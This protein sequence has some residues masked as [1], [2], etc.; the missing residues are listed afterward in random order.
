MATPVANAAVVRILLVESDPALSRSLSALLVARPRVGVDVVSNPEEAWERL[1]DAAPY[2]ISVI[3]DEDAVASLGLL[4]RIKGHSPRTKTIFLTQPGEQRALQAVRAGASHCLPKPVDPKELADVLA[5]SLR[6]RLHPIER[7]LAQSAEMATRLSAECDQERLYQALADGVHSLGFDRVRLYAMSADGRAL[8]AK[9]QAGTGEGAVA[10]LSSPSQTYPISREQHA[11]LLE[12]VAHV[13][14]AGAADRLTPEKELGLGS[15]EPLVLLPLR[16]QGKV[17]GLLSADN[18]LS[19]RRVR[20]R[21]LIPLVFLVT[22]A[23]AAL[24]GARLF[25]SAQRRSEQLE[26]LRRTTLAITSEWDRA[27]LLDAVLRQAVALL[28]A[29]GGGIYEY[30]PERGALE[31]ICDHN[32]PHNVGRVLRVGD[33]MAG[34][35]VDSGEPYLIVHDYDQWPGRSPIY[36]EPRLFGAVLEVPLRWGNR[37]LGVLYV[38]DSVGR[39]FTVEDAQLLGLFADQAAI[40][41]ANADLI[42]RDKGKLR[43]LEAL[44][45][46][47]REI[48]GDLKGIL[49]QDRLSLIARRAAEILDA[50]CC[51]VHLV[52]HEGE[53]TLAASYGHREGQFQRG[54]RTK[55]CTGKG[56]GLTGHV[57][58]EGRLFNMHGEALTAHFAVR[59][60]GGHHSPSGRCHSLLA[61]PLKRKDGERETLVGLLRVDNKKRP[62]GESLP[63][64]GFSQEDEWIIAV[65]AEAV[66]IAIDSADL[67]AHL[68]GL[69]DNSPS[70]IVSAD[71]K[72]RVTAI[73]ARAR[74]MLKYPVERS[75]VG[76][77]V[78]SLYYEPSEPLRVGQRMH[79][80]GHSLPRCET[81]VR[82]SDGERIPIQLTATWLR[83]GLGER[84]GTVGYFEDLRSSEAGQRLALLLQAGRILADAAELRS[85]L[86]ALTELLVTT[87][88]ATFCRVFLLDASRN[89]LVACAAHPIPRAGS[90]LSW[91]PG[92]DERL[93][94]AEWDRLDDFLKEGSPLVLRA[95][96]RS[97]GEI[98]RRW[99]V[100][101]ELEA[102][103]QSLLVVPLRT[104]GKVIGLLDV[105]EVRPDRA[106]IREDTAR[107]VGTI[108][109]QAALFIDM[110]SLQE[111]QKRRTGLLQELDRASWHVRGQDDTAALRQDITRLGAQLFGCAGG[112]FYVNHA[113]LA[114]LELVARWGAYPQAAGTWVPHADAFVGRVARKGEAAVAHEHS[115]GVAGSPVSG[116]VAAVPLEYG[117]SIEAVLAVADP[118]EPKSDLEE[119]LDILERFATQASRS[120]Q[121]ARLLNPAE[122]AL[123]H[124]DI[125]HRVSDYIQTADDLDKVL[126]VV[127][128]A[129]TADYGLGLNRAA[130]FLLDDAGQSLEGKVGIGHLNEAETRADW[131]W[132]DGLDFS[133]YVRA[134]EAGEM[135][136]TPVGRAV[137]GLRLRVG[138]TAQDLFCRALRERR[139]IVL[140]SGDLT[141]LPA[142]FVQAFR[143][144]LPFVVVPLVARGQA[145]GLLAVDNQVSR[146]AIADQRL[147]SLLTFAN[148]A[149]VVIDNRRLFLQSDEARRRLQSFFRAAAD[150]FSRAV[151]IPGEHEALQHL[152]DQTCA[153]A[154]ASWSSLILFEDPER[155]PRMITSPSGRFKGDIAEILR[156]DGI[157]M[158]VLESGVPEVIRDANRERERVNPVMFETASAA[159]ICLPLA[160]RGA[161]VG[162]VWIHYDAPRDFPSFEID[163]LRLYLD[164]VAATYEGLRRSNEV[165]QMHQVAQALTGAASLRDVLVRVVQGARQ[166]LGS[167][168]AMLLSFD[169]ARTRFLPDASVAEG[170]PEAAWDS[171]RRRAA[172]LSPKDLKGFREDG[173]LDIRDAS[174]APEATLEPLNRELLAGLGTEGLGGVALRVGEDALC[175]LYVLYRKPG[176]LRKEER[177]TAETFASH[178]VVALRRAR[179]QEQAQRAKSAAEAV[180]KITTLGDTAR[181]LLAVA[182]GTR[183]AT[184]CDAVVLYATTRLP[185]RSTCRPPRWDSETEKR[186]ARG[187]WLRRASLGR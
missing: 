151:P 108:G 154:G 176:R 21:T 129:I 115:W 68:E 139:P 111:A 32:R 62:N 148:T 91:R 138:D 36:G 48:M 88:G 161:R 170:L 79:E 25:A 61:I 169:T 118:P 17:I 175:A 186:W 177:A 46:A 50:E 35:L 63:T 137:S 98:L 103:L 30:H 141:G 8:E 92:L 164:H 104:R 9:A 31:V 140:N 14:R 149:A 143:P 72:G 56:T 24:E 168:A 122:R 77:P 113:G 173:W 37:T 51:G 166:V 55:I 157:S 47:V 20:R 65:F 84:R 95:T 38:D 2:D 93:A 28:R 71:L 49:L 81:S 150:L 146:L 174:V 131:R 126:H 102:P 185:T 90:E 107:L 57:A 142:E 66:V 40:A 159:A 23:S 82:A 15:D 133:K 78:G 178:A 163:A 5:L 97:G 6:Q 83:D 124:L 87:L 43:R 75:V 167:H 33:G 11:A 187:S 7:I 145:I 34:R 54:L 171:V 27:Q 158:R 109:E 172:E 70:G 67:V 4:S 128:T 89:A 64:V 53:L 19:Q 130:L 100:R 1:K 165:E 119:N 156:P 60:A 106:P 116:V 121:T 123:A 85:G 86:G 13:V 52:R 69:F 73:N 153:A 3:D 110:L 74:E 26:A 10:S 45:R 183:D 160:L 42:A 181:A 179:L 144:T 182:E 58:F 96:G 22:Q 127:L 180:A 152:A 136:V 132:S 105:G 44:A 112:G 59:S 101:L 134:L 184:G 80:A 29:S 41:L 18:A 12:N 76:E 16:H 99:S 120:L 94:L 155:L 39:R 125:L 147:D 117:G 114:T 135:Q 162:V